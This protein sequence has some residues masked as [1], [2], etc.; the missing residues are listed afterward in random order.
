MMKIYLKCLWSHSKILVGYI[1]LIILLAVIVVLEGQ[2]LTMIG[3]VIAVSWLFVVLWWLYTSYTTLQAIKR[4][5]DETNDN[6]PQKTLIERAYLQRMSA[7]EAK[8]KQQSAKIIDDYEQRMDYLTTWSHAIKTPLTALKLLAQNQPQI[9][10]K[11]VSSEVDWALYQLDLLLNYERLADFNADIVV[12]HVNLERLVNQVA[13][14]NMSFFISQD[15]AL[16]VTLRDAV[17]LSDEKWLMVVI[18][19]LLINASKYSNP[20]QRVEISFCPQT[21]TL[22]IKDYGVGILPSDMPR[23]FERGFTGHNGRMTSK[24]S[25]MGLYLVKQICDLL[26]I[27]LQVKSKPNQGCAFL[28]TFS[29]DAM[30]FD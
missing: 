26:H 23:I 22:T 21:A 1:S 14:K 12:A 16:K 9:T 24:A 15:I 6:L 5:N 25:G 28:L 4:I 13:Q 27:T 30:V 10:S 29:Q 18:E 11:Q 17:V 19:Q 20:H 3:D 7:D 8:I 2:K